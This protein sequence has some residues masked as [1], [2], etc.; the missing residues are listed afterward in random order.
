ME[1]FTVVNFIELSLSMVM[2]KSKVNELVDVF[3]TN[4]KLS[5]EQSKSVALWLLC[6]GNWLE[7]SLLRLA[8]L[9]LQ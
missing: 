9:T 4:M 7:A 8:Y 6:K 1:I 3:V 5:Y 2:E